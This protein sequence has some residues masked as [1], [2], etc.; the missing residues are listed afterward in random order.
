MS[1]SVSGIS[2]SKQHTPQCR[3]GATSEQVE[4]L[5][6]LEAFI[7]AVLIQ[8]IF[9]QIYLSC[10]LNSSLKIL[11][12]EMRIRFLA[13]G[14]VMPQETGLLQDKVMLQDKVI[15]EEKATL[16]CHPATSCFLSSSLYSTNPHIL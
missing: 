3:Q 5:M 2:V 15:P 1:S 10:S 14:K 8:G 11:H 12:A 6:R 7:L 9:V 16:F 13:S 4:L